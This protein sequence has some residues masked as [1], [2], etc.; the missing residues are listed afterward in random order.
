MFTRRFSGL[1]GIISFT[2]MAVV[3]VSILVLL[4]LPSI[5]IWC[6]SLFAGG[7]LFLQVISAL[8][9]SAKRSQEFSAFEHNKLGDPVTEEFQPPYNRSLPFD[10]TE[11]VLAWCAPVMQVNS[12]A[13]LFK[14]GSWGFLGKGKTTNAENALL[15]T[16][17]RLLF[18]MIGPDSLKRYSSSPKVTSLLET[19]P[20]DASAK[21]RMLWQMGASEVH[22]ALAGLIAKE[23]LEHLAQT[24]YSFSIPLND[25][26]SVT[27]SPHNRILKI[28]R[29]GVTLQY[30][31]KTKEEL[32][33][34]TDKLA[35]LGL[36]TD[37]QKKT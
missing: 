21:R 3:V 16:Q 33:S 31:F 30:C 25:I 34:L 13:D 24:H 10:S 28:Q 6:G 17:K 19:L 20:G 36:L 4:E 35:K 18:L 2:I 12:L 26:S 8:R 11:T 15:L 9:G 23:N 37:F 14:V 32:T 5:V 27:P 1:W 7:L 29:D 22:D